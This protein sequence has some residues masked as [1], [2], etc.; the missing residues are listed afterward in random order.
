VLEAMLDHPP[1]A[2]ILQTRSPQVV[3]HLP[4]LLKLA[5]R[6]R[7][8]VHL[9]VETDRLGLEGLPPAAST[10]QARLTAARTLKVA[11]L[12]VVITVSPLLPIADPDKFFEAV[13]ECGTAVVLDHFIGGDGSSLGSRTLRTALPQAMAAV[14]ADSVLLAYRDRMAAVAARIMPGRVGLSIDGFAGRFS[15]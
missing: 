9:T 10:P 7:L 12:P 1:D 14:E 8:R 13:A 11:G 6:T 4:L 2:L 3:D 15:L 5:A